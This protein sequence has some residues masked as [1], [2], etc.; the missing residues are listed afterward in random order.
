[1]SETPLVS[2]ENLSVSYG[3]TPAVKQLSFVIPRGEVFGFIGPN[4]AGKTS[5]IK[6]LATLQKP[7]SGRALVA[8]HDVVQSPQYVR[9]KI[10]YMPDFFG[11]YDDLTAREY[12]HFFAA[13][14]QVEPS[15]RASVVRDVLALTDLSE[16]VDAPVD[17]LSRGMKQRLGLARVL[18]HDPDLLLLDEPASGLDPRA[19]IEM[20]EL[21]KEL[22]GM[23]KTII[24]SSHI[25]HELSQ[26]CTSI[27]IIEAGQMVA[28]GSL[29][30]IYRA[31]SLRRTIHIQLANPSLSLANSIREI[32]GVAGVE[33]HADRYGVQIREDELAPEDLLSAIHHLGGR[34]RMFQ[35]DAMDMETAFMK[36]TE[37]KTA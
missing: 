34:V 8:G 5:T 2:V 7:S 25:L 30:D 31:L 6:V 3:K 32:A 10:G 18:L 14:Y 35:P 19:R 15:R 9:R 17:G 26:F 27:G 13:A 4:G 28:H 16:K 11:V 37:G 33:E 36:L 22:Q 20:R 23:G 24:V 29:K 1:M 12:L 21:L